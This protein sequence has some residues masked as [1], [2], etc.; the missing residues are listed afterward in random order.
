MKFWG[1]V[2]F[3]LPL[4]GTA[5]VCWRTWQILPLPVR[6]KAA[7]VTLMILCIVSLFVTFLG[8]IDRWPMWAARTVYIVG[9]SSI[10]ILLYLVLL[11]L[12]LDLGRLVRL[13]PPSFLHNSLAGTLTVLG[14][15]LAVFIGGNINYHIKRRVKINIDSPKKLERPLKIVMLSDLHIGY[16]NT[17]QELHRWVDIVNA[18]HPDLIL[19]AGDIIDGS[20]RPLYEEDM[21]SEFHRLKAPVYAC[22]GNHEYIGDIG[23]SL[24]FYADA[25]IHM[26]RDSHVV[27]DGI[28]IIGRDDRTNYRRLPMRDLT[29]DI[30]SYKFTILMDHQPYNLEESM[31][32]GIDFQLSGHTHYGQVWPISWITDAIYED[33]YGPLK[34]GRTAYFVSSGL[35]IWGAPYRIGTHSEYLVVNVLPHKRAVQNGGE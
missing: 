9:C 34:K 21:A 16:L 30:D 12:L 18:E 35:G 14:I 11:Y 5:Y 4:L 2:F 22:L 10:F 8:G 1:I 20:T 27:V 31:K 19:I 23:Q 28:N 25:G 17:R 26:L 7:A 13:I 3:L 33:A 15:M 32:G 29:R 24:K 6:G